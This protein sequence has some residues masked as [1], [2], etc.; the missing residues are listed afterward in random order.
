MHIAAHYLIVYCVS[1]HLIMHSCTI[2]IVLT[3]LNKYGKREW[4][5]FI[6]LYTHRTNDYLSELLKCFAKTAMIPLSPSKHLYGAKMRNFE[7][8]SLRVSVFYFPSNHSSSN[9]LLAYS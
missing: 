6:L 3:G 1:L 5:V 8:P 2:L 9:S 4:A 7:C